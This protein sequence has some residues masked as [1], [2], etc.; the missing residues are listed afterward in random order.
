MNNIANG[1]EPID[2]LWLLV[3]DHRAIIFNVLECMQHIISKV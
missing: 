1:I 3:A 2:R